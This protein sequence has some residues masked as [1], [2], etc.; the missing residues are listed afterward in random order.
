VSLIVPNQDR[1]SKENPK[2]GE[3]LKKIQDYT[4]LNISPAVGNRVPPPPTN[5]ANPQG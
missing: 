2:L 4:N 5:P 3:A 1:I